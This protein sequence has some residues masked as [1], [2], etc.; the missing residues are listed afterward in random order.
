MKGDLTKPIAS[1]EGIAYSATVPTVKREGITLLRYYVP[2]H[3]VTLLQPTRNHKVCNVCSL[4]KL[5]G[6]ERKSTL[7]TMVLDRLPSESI[8]SPCGRATT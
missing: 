4:A 1:L 6:A 7:L 2:V 5:F 8:P 3:K